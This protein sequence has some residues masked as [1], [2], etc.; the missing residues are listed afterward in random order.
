MLQSRGSQSLRHDLA[1]EQPPRDVCIMTGGGACY[2]DLVHN[3]EGHCSMSH[4]AQ[5]SPTTKDNLAPK[6]NK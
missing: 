2:W 3:G 4:D 6:V 5:N 1:T